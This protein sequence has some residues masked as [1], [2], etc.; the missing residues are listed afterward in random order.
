MLGS[1]ADFVAS[2]PAAAPPTPDV[3]D[4]TIRSPKTVKETVASSS[5][6][7]RRWGVITSLQPEDFRQ[8][9]RVAREGS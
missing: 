2:S 6:L 8:T 4:A 7:S 9:L 3:L 5:E 1:F